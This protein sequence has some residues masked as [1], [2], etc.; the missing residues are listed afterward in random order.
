MKKYLILFVT[1]LTSLIFCVSNVSAAK[2]SYTQNNYAIVNTYGATIE[3]VQSHLKN[4]PVLNNNSFISILQRARELIENN[5]I[6]DYYMFLYRN[7]SSPY[8]LLIF[9]NEENVIRD[10]YTVFQKSLY[11]EL[12][13][14]FYFKTNTKITGY[15]V[16]STSSKVSNSMDMGAATANGTSNL[17]YE[18]NYSQDYYYSN[19]DAYDTFIANGISYTNGDFVFNTMTGLNSIEL[20]PKIYK[21]EDEI[22]TSN[23]SYIKINYNT[24]GSTYDD[25]SFVVM[26]NVS[27]KL[28]EAYF[29]K[30]YDWGIC[31]DENTCYDKYVYRDN[32]YYTNEANMYSASF[33]FKFED[34][35]HGYYDET[36]EL[37][38][39]YAY[40]DVSSISDIVTLSID[41]TKEFSV[42]FGYMEDYVDT[43]V[44][45]DLKNYSGI[46][47]FPKVNLYNGDY[48][49]YLKNADVNVHHYYENNLVNIYKNIIVETYRIDQVEYQDRNR[50]YLIE[51][52]KV[53]QNSYISFDTRYFSYQLVNTTSETITITNPNTNEDQN[54]SS[55]DSSNL[56]YDI[57]H[58]LDNVDSLVERVGIF[59]DSMKEY[60]SIISEL[61]DCAYSNLNSDCQLFIVVI[62]I[63]ILIVGLI[64][65]LRR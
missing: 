3:Q 37:D 33:P 55:I 50:Y 31:L 21:Y 35:N 9:F 46:V 58:K 60:I 2:G 26:N 15:Y 62:F 45:I 1:L 32:L 24:S 12:T 44:E 19:N 52:N 4:Y 53:D 20:G 25:Y 56:D 18:T 16:Y 47:L 8:A 30:S 38:Y 63:I 10:N 51:N 14:N 23:L 42:E 5:K 7:E 13:T 49:F 41:S 6:S 17:Y 48:V 40:Y 28:K 61:F 43:F 65:L 39:F 22:D 11:A 27:S 57:S 59:I 54:I 64:L 34:S 36:Q 29:E